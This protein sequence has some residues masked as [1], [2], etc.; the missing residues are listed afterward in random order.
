MVEWKETVLQDIIELTGG[1]TPKTSIKEYWNGDIKW[2]SVKDF[3]GDL[4]YVYNTEKTITELGLMN[5]STKLLDKDDIIIS[6]RGTV[7]EIAMIPYPMAFNQSCYG[8]KAKKGIDKIFLYYLLKNEVYQLKNNSHGSVFDTITRNTFSNINVKIPNIDIQKKIASALC[9]LDDKIELNKKINDNLE[10]QAQLLFSQDFGQYTFATN[11]SEESD[12]PCSWKYYK[13]V[14]LCKHIKPGT[15][16]QPKRVETGIPF[17]NVRCV[18][19]GYID[20]SDA[21]FITEVDYT[22]VHKTWQPE[23]NDLLISRI[24]TLGLVAA[25]RKEDLPI[26]V[27]YNFINIKPSKLPFE[28]MYFL[29]KS[30]QFQ[31]VYHF[32]KKHSVQEYVTI[33]EVE[34]IRIPL[35]DINTIDFSLYKDI[36][37]MIV[38]NQRENK[39]LIHLRDE[40]LPKLMS[41]ELDVSDIEF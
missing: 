32:I 25:I 3:S 11:D 33:D 24:G 18:N 15:N 40:L 41:G 31:T 6:A 13:M 30:K 19:R 35:P 22:R 38:S 39:M 2:L 1:G 36:Y 9:K 14:D 17:L 23:E 20:T 26:A 21:K 29:L 8:I 34:D 7:G 12:L 28:F 27:H 16:F 37:T 4:R 5:S 10:Q